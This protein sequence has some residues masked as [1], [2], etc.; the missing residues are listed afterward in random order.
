MSMSMTYIQ[1]NFY[2]TYYMY[3]SENNLTISSKETLLL[4]LLQQFLGLF[5][6][7][8]SHLSGS[9]SINSLCEVT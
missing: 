8:D 1:L 9:A 3:S 6:V 2:Q 7:T 5:A 4:S